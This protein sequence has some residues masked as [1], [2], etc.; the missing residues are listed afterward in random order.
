MGAEVEVNGNAVGVTPLS[1]SVAVSPGKVRV[2]LRRTGD[3]P[4]ERTVTLDDG[5]RGELAFTLDEDPAAP[6]STKGVLRLAALEGD[7]EVSV[8][9]VPRKLS[10]ASLSLP[11]GLTL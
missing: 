10:G 4:V 11:V 7:A 6:P 9:G 3:S 5:A 2:V 1:A 8:D